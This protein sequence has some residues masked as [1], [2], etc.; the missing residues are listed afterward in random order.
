MASR[1]ELLEHSRRCDERHK[2]IDDKLGRIDKAME[3]F[4]GTLIKVLIST[5][6]GLVIGLGV[7]ALKLLE[8]HQ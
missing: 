1:S 7:L 5:V 4:N 8:L 3:R 2:I 6:G